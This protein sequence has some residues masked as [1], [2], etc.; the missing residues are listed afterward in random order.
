MHFG[1]K[2]GRTSVGNGGFA[3]VYGCFPCFLDFP[4]NLPSLFPSV[5]AVVLKFSVVF[6]GF[7]NLNRK[8][9]FLHFPVT[10]FSDDFTVVFPVRRFF[11]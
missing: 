8:T 9:L 10:E 6:P 1:M 5:F 7:C 4:L 3:L 2:P 11:H